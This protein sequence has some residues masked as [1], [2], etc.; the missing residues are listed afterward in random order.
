LD[1]TSSAKRHFAEGIYRYIEKYRIPVILLPHAPHHS[2]GTAF[3]RFTSKNPLPAYS[4][5]WMPFLYDHYWDTMPNYRGRF[6]YIGYPGMDSTWLTYLR[7]SCTQNPE[8]N[9]IR[10]M[11]VIRRFLEKHQCRN[12]GDNQFVYNYDEME[13]FIRLV[14]DGLNQLNRPYSL[15]IKPHPSNSIHTV[16]KIFSESDIYNWSITKEPIYAHLSNLDGVV[17]LYS[18]AGLIS[19]INGVPLVMLQT[20]THEHIFQWDHLKRLYTGMSYYLTDPREFNHTISEALEHKNEPK[21]STSPMI[22]DIKH[23]RDFFPDG[24][25][26]RATKSIKNMISS[27][28]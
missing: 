15:V 7:E 19:A 16:E 12:V 4:R 22:R 21:K 10:C 8:T 9:E 5:C 27:G 23:L 24:A 25:I 3:T 18:T 14:S 13:K 17:S 1:S 28:G 6:E 20:S 11:F 2:N 26:E